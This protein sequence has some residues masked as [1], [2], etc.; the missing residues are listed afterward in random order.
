MKHSVSH[1]A[2]YLAGTLSVVAFAVTVM[3]APFWSAMLAWL[4]AYGAVAATPESRRRHLTLVATMLLVLG[5]SPLGTSTEINPGAIMTLGMLVAVG[6]PFLVQKLSKVDA[7]LLHLR[8]RWGWPTKREWGYIV[9]AA[10]LTSPVIVLYFL[11]SGAGHGWHMESFADTLV[12]FAA[13]MIIGA[14]EEVFFIAA[15]FG[16]LRKYLPYRVAN[17]L[18]ASAFTM[19]LYAFG[20]GGWVL[21]FVLWYTY[22]Q[23]FVYYKTGNLLVTL[24]IHAIVDLCV[25]LAILFS[26]QPSWLFG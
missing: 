8:L 6:L 11:T 21:I 14:W 20:F 13:I 9:F 24:I 1:L 5:I 19:F 15:I 18:Q 12:S 17:I 2:T 7:D 10:C 16:I 4:A 26:I 25:F 3:D 23:G 22:Y